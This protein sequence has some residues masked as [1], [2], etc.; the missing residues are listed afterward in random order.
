MIAAEDEVIQ[1]YARFMEPI[2]NKLAWNLLW[3]IT[4]EERNTPANFSFTFRYG[5]RT[6][7]AFTTKEWVKPMKKL[8]S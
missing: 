6:N 7:R 8:K 5:P 3:D 2:G 4:N 1:L